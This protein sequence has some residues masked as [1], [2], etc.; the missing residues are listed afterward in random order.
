VLTAEPL[1]QGQFV[2]EFRGQIIDAKLAARRERVY[3]GTNTGCYM[4]VVPRTSLI[5]DPT[6]RRPEYGMSPYLNHA[7][8]EHCTLF[9]RRVRVDG[10]LRVAM[11][12]MR[13]VAVGEQ[14]TFDYG[15]RRP[16]VCERYPFLK[17]T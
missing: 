12:A 11:F 14:L 17:R 2:M 3:E 1:K 5:I 9:P 6:A 13:D 10:Q 7:P 15:D 8:R 4:M 16:S